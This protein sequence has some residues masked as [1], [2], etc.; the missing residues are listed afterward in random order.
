MEKNRIR[1]LAE[2]YLKE[3]NQA[4]DACKYV[5]PIRNPLLVS[6]YSQLIGL[7]QPEE[8]WE[9]VFRAEG[10]PSGRLHGPN[11]TVV[12]VEPESG[13]CVIAP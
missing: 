11:T 12:V 6:A 9:A 8:L 1:R 7:E 5:A 13:V 3:Q 10:V 2:A 4:F